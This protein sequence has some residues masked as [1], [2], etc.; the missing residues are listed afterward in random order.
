MGC[1][2]KGGKPEHRSR[3]TDYQYVMALIQSGGLAVYGRFLHCP[4]FRA[5][6]LLQHHPDRHDLVH[7]LR[8]TAFGSA[9]PPLA[10]GRL[11]RSIEEQ[12]LP[13]A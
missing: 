8:Q 13:Y 12:N 9:E 2:D 6:V 4:L 3:I 10:M 1:G 11:Y 7:D 5:V